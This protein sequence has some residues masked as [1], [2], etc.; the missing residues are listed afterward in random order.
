[1]LTPGYS[2]GAVAGRRSVMA[3]L[4]YALVLVGAFAVLLL[5]LRGL[6]RL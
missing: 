2:R 3:D 6:Q 5:T 4:A 1:M